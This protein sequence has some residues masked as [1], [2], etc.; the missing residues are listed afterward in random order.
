MWTRQELPSWIEEHAASLCT[1]SQSLSK[2]PGDSVLRASI[3][4]GV[5]AVFL[6]LLHAIESGDDE[7]WTIAG[8]PVCG[9]R[10]A[11]ARPFSL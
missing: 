10:P 9:E 11:R 5:D 2:G 6:S 4:E 1:I 3:C 7:L 8:T